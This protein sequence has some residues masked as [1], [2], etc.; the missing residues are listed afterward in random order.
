MALGTRCE[1][2]ELEKEHLSSVVLTLFGS[3]VHRNHY[4]PLRR[5]L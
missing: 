1:P 5:L 2:D 3:T 4:L